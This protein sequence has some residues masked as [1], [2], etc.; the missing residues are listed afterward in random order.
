MVVGS[1]AEQYV[2]M[3]DT[4]VASGASRYTSK[5]TSVKISHPGLKRAGWQ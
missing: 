1:N 5:T 2:P 4:T 3:E